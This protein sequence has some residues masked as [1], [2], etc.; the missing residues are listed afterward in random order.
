M[1]PE[2]Y[3]LK[4]I[5]AVLSKHAQRA[6]YGAVGGLVHLP[7]RSV[8]FGQ[9]KTHANSYVVAV[10]SRMPTGYSSAERH[11]NLAS[12]ANVISSPA[13]LATWLH[14]HH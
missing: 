9:P 3:E 5:V 14:E 12:L 13:T 10:K 11:P 7:A 8:M 1:N 4:E 2:R 6:T